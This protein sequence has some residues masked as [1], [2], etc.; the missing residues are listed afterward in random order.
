M[1]TDTIEGSGFPLA[2]K[3]RDG[4]VAD[5]VSGK[6]PARDVYRVEARTMGDAYAMRSA[7]SS[8]PK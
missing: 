4:K 8:R 5:V 1:S 2:F 7:S 3:V 6:A